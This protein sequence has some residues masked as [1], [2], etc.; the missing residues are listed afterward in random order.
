MGPCPS[1][2]TG[3][4]LVQIL[5]QFAVKTCPHFRPPP[6]PVFETMKSQNSNGFREQNVSKSA[7]WSLLKPSYT[8]GDFSIAGAGVGVKKEPSYTYGDFQTTDAV[9]GV[10][11]DLS[12]TYGDFQTTGAVQRA[13]KGFKTHFWAHL[14]YLWIG[15]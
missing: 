7:S 10:K 1:V 9:V 11:K 15:K 5:T 12:Y 4:R 13:S 6:D 3:T 14:G 8:Y 2:V